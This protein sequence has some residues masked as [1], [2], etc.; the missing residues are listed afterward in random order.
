VIQVSGAFTA[1]CSYCTAIL[2]NRYL[3]LR[4]SGSLTHLVTW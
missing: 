2:L 3:V 4:L 1:I